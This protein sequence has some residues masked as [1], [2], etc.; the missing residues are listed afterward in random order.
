MDQP[1]LNKVVCY[2][3]HQVPEVAALSTVAVTQLRTVKRKRFVKM[4]VIQM[5]RPVNQ[6][7]VPIRSHVPVLNLILICPRGHKVEVMT[8]P[9]RK[10]P[11]VVISRIFTK[12]V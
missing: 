8:K 9:K 5:D 7:N 2:Q 1:G 3:H 6:E 12:A 10:I 4:E 11:T